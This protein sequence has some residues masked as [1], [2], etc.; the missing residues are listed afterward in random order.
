MGDC[1]L[2][3]VN[4]ALVHDF[5][6]PKRHQ[7]RKALGGKCPKRID[8]PVSDGQGGIQAVHLL[9]FQGGKLA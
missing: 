8:F 7:H 5:L 3:A 9:V 2:P 1:V 6:H 4:A